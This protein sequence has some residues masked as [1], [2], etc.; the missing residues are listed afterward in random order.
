M[1]ILLATDLSAASELATDW[2][3]DLARKLRSTLLIVSVIDARQ[4]Q[5]SG[6]TPF[7][8]RVDQIRSRREDAAQE[9]VARGHRLG[10]PVEF[11]VWEGEPGPSIVEAALSEEADLVL[12]G[13]HGRG[14][15]GRLLMG[16]V[17]AHVVAHA[18]CPVLVVR[19]A[20]HARHADGRAVQIERQ[21]S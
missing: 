18:P 4:Q 15:L 17:S 12:V 10:I 6:P 9:V 3:F 11:L 19:A 16:S 1:K 2:A 5:H 21:A 20:R 14:V 7:A 8:Q 13:S